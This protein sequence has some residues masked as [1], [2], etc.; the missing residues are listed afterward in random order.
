MRAREILVQAVDSYRKQQWLPCLE[1]T[2]VLIAFYPDL[3]ES[4][5]A[6]QLAARSI[7]MCWKNLA[8]I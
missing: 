6:R 8:R 4:V 5:D 7:P 1:Q 2:R 3:P